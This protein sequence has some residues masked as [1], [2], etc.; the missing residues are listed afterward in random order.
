MTRNQSPNPANT[1]DID[2]CIFPKLSNHEGDIPE[3]KESKRIEILV[4]PICGILRAQNIALNSFILAAWAVTVR[5]FTECQTAQFWVRKQT[6][7]DGPTP[8]SSIPI[9][10]QTSMRVLC[11]NA[12]R[13]IIQP[14]Q[15]GHNACNIGI[16]FLNVVDM[17]CLSL[18]NEASGDV[19]S[20]PGCD[21]TI[22]VRRN[23]NCLQIYLHYN[24]TLLSNTAANNVVST[25]HQAVLGGIES[26][27]GPIC[28]LP[29]CSKVH[30]RQIDAFN[31][32]GAVPSIRPRLPWWHALKQSFLEKGD[33]RGKLALD[34]WDGQFTFGELEQT[35][36][37]IAAHLQALGIGPR[38]MIPVCFEKSAWAVVAA[39]S[40]HISGA[41]FVPL[42][43][44]L[45]VSRIHKIIAAVES[46][47][48]VVSPLQ[49]HI[50]EGLSLSSIVVSRDTV[51]TFPAAYGDMAHPAESM[52]DPAYCLFTSGSTGNPKGC[53]I[54][55]GALA[56][57][58]DHC[59]MLS[60]NAT[61][62]SLQFAS[63]SFGISII[64]IYC[65]LGVGGTVCVISE[66]D[67][68]SLRNLGSAITRMRI[69]WAFMTPTMVGSLD[70]KDV[71]CLKAIVTGGEPLQKGQVFTWANSVN[72]HQALGFTEWTGVCCVSSRITSPS[73]VGLIGKPVPNARAWLVDPGNH[74]FLAP[75]GAVAELCIEGPCLAQGY[76]ND[77]EKTSKAFLD[78]PS[79]A[80]NS[81]PPN[82]RI[83]GRLYK[84]GDLVR[85]MCDGS[86]KY[87]GRNDTQRKIRG[88]R[89]EIGEVEYHLRQCFPQALRVFAEVISPRNETGGGQV[90]TGFIQA[91]QSVA[92]SRA[93]KDGLFN[94][95]DR[96]FQSQANKARE[97]LSTRLPRYMVPDLFLSLCSVPLTISGKLDRRRICTYA[98]QHS[99]REL[100]GKDSFDQSQYRAPS[101]EMEIILAMLVADVLNTPAEKVGVDDDFF[102][103]GGDSIK[104]MALVGEANRQHHVSITMAQILS[105]PT[106]ARLAN[107]AKR[108]ST[109]REVNRAVAPF[110]MLHKSDTREEMIQTACDQCQVDQAGVEDIYPC[111]PLQEGMFALGRK[112][113]GGY[114]ARWTYDFHGMSDAE[115]ARLK[116]AWIRVFEEDVSLRSRIILS[117]S[118]H[119]YQVVL[120]EIPMH[121]HSHMISDG[122]PQNENLDLVVEFGRPLAKISFRRY[123]TANSLQVALTM[124]H[125]VIDG[126]CFRK[127]LDQVEAVYH[128]KALP[129]SS[130]F[131]GFVHYLRQ[132][133][134]HKEYWTNHLAGL[135]AEVFP[136]ISPLS[137]RPS[138]T[139]EASDWIGSIDFTTGRFTRSA[140]L[141][142][143][144][145]MVQAQY[146]NNNDIVYG[147]TVSGRNAPVAGIL[148]MASPTVATIPL[149]VQL[150]PAASIEDTLNNLVEQTVR[151]IPHEQ[152]GLQT[153]R[154]WGGDIAAACD[155]QTLLVIQHIDGNSG[156]SLLGTEAQESSFAAFC[157]YTLTLVCNLN[158][159]PVE[160]KAW[161]DPNLVTEQQVKRMLRQ[162]KHVVQTICKTPL[163]TVQDCMT[164][165][166]SDTEEVYSWNR[167]IPVLSDQTVTELISSRCI[168][169]PSRLAVDAWDVQFT[170]G[171][172]DEFSTNLAKHLL[173]MGVQPGEFVP[174]CSEKSGW[175]VVSML[176]VMKSGAAFILLDPSVPKQR[177]IQ[178]CQQA[179]S[180]IIITTSSTIQ[181]AMKIVTRVVMA[182]DRYPS[183]EDISLPTVGP[184]RPLFAVFTSGSTGIPKAA[185]ADHQ[186]FLAYSRPIIKGTRIDETARC[187]QF[188]SYA[189]DMSVNETLW[190][191]LGGACL[192]ILSDSQ[193][194]NDFVDTV[195]KLR[196]THAVFTPS[197]LRSLD[198]QELPSL[199]AVMVGGEL[200]QPS[201]VETWSPHV[202]MTIGYG[203]AE[204]GVTHLRYFRN[205][206]D[207]PYNSVGFQTGGASWLVAPG[208][209]EKL[210]PIGAVGELLLEGP[211]VGPGYLQNPEKTKESFIPAP[212]FVTELRGAATRV[213]KTGDLLRY[214]FD[215]SLSFVGRIDSQVKVRGQR[216][217]LA[218][219]ETHLKACFPSAVQIV[220]ELISPKDGKTAPFL[221]GFVHAGI[222]DDGQTPGEWEETTPGCSAFYKPERTFQ[223]QASL[224]IA[225]LRDRVPRF[226]V[227]SM[228]INLSYMPQTMSGKVDRKFLQRALV[229]L[230]DE[231]L[232]QFRAGIEQKRGAV[233]EMEKKI[234]GFCA[235]ALQIPLQ[236][237]GLE[238]SFLQLGGDS[239][240]AM[241]MAAEARKEGIQISVADILDNPR[242]STLATYAQCHNGL[243]SG[244]S[245]MN[246]YS[247]ADIKPFTLVD[248]GLRAEATRQLLKLRIINHDSHVVDIQP[249][250]ES[251]RNFLTQWTPVL[252]CYFLSGLV[253]GKRLRDACQAVVSIHSILRTAFL[254]INY[255]TVQAV[256]HDMDLPFH[257]TTTDEDLLTYCDAI[258]QSDSDISSTINTAPLRLTFVSRSATEHAFVIRMSHAQYDGI[259][260]PTLIRD[261]G[262][263]YSGGKI[264]PIIDFATYMHL[265]SS[266]DH[267]A[268]F[269]F[270]RQYLLD[271]SVRPLSL[272]I[273][274]PTKA[275]TH[276]RITTG[277]NIPMPALPVGLT[278]ATLVK[279]AAAWLVT[280][281]GGQDDI[282]L[283][284]TVTGRSMPVVG[285]EK[286][287][288]PCLNTIPFR[289]KLQPG[290]TILKLLQHVQKQCSRTFEYD[291]VDLEDIVR[292]S[293]DWPQDSYL[294]CVIQHQNVAEASTLLLKD[295]ECTSSGWA[296]FTPPA[297]MWIL[298]TPQDTTLQVMLCASRSVL[299]METAKSWVNE[300]C[301]TITMFASQPARLLD[302]IDV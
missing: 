71:L 56:G 92:D 149:R 106:V 156:Y 235:I 207:D 21:V 114:V 151:S 210:V 68:S 150:D 269:D 131:T 200:V 75:V 280:R 279:A 4:S 186:S 299:S 9:D 254:E 221:A 213:Y 215:G 135:N 253:D 180:Q 290:W 283:G 173:E 250:T 14:R 105:R 159:D 81:C 145:A 84:T 129:P 301:S 36:C 282:V 19:K 123:R 141:R 57:L 115:T 27:D 292:T 49:Q 152:T 182:D 233:N 174:I 147:V 54:S 146:Q 51:A 216:I 195:A 121:D 144:W 77:A 183:I 113:H 93:S 161:F 241:Y 260:M 169:Q 142:L 172:L 284:Q 285:V 211:F 101:S 193:R 76:L 99:R 194:L 143:A 227:P 44:S 294:P 6:E 48:A 191:L 187:L 140:V 248:D 3:W 124:H 122:N 220:V 90:L 58:V 274:A 225:R 257:Q 302:N 153:M 157:T 95:V 251:Q 29:L 70:P 163:S 37:K 60:L 232:K 296:Y 295:V 139:G 26:L 112:Q 91:K 234:Q 65:T 85:Y 175:T 263:A 111:T 203:P 246:S 262:E 28:N 179:E 288:G 264:E 20:P 74:A 127:I 226:M 293:T 265:R 107:I 258:W 171:A 32:N 87:L 50:L 252:N 8:L 237:I 148:T 96:V 178:S 67:C 24:D 167:Q 168:S 165:N 243:S 189:F 230:P 236:D 39:I 155:F 12:E 125:S 201:D 181:I 104:A 259:S 229:D 268:T 83:N 35:C 15:T 277:Q 286:M 192:C 40:I 66:E 116:Q 170:Y 62:C 108:K 73:S 132:L 291:Y 63:Y 202:E 287:L 41:A 120:K 46:R 218:D 82:S 59:E 109:M 79:W 297:G 45:P 100:L 88:Q 97:I 11:Q 197:F 86:I 134:D 94:P 55:Q 256:L 214:N 300:L 38:M 69:N 219:V 126:W 190:T 228:L 117:A 98:H 52:D 2:V 158:S 13:T 198:P 23:L 205:S 244:L 133:P 270:W 212:G 33:N 261:L 185:M 176:A 103:L 281:S 130:P 118:Q 240:S 208:E 278:V 184:D 53:I 42:D 17:D 245:N 238:D 196:P 267:T 64:E 10:P 272:P 89:I 199:R 273:P 137:Y 16:V 7:D 223:E 247:S 110:S 5:S 43:P 271:S 188:S 119:M 217:E 136:A 276:T 138:P 34:G 275:S 1:E 22:Y 80:L 231:E 47:F 160:L 102:H 255:A 18:C 31:I 206:P 25:V 266:H 209:C 162:L 224:A 204:S 298:S 154:K 78:H 222:E 289:V 242:L 239:I 30:M 72:L 166:A 164:I 177:L 249:V 61:C 128:G